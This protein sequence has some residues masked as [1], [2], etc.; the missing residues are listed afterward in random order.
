MA[1]YLVIQVSAF[2]SRYIPRPWRY[3]IGTAVGEAVYWA[4]TSK[5]Q[6]LLQNMAT[7]LGLDPSD[8]RVRPVARRSMRNYCKYLIEFLELP[9]LSAS[10]SVVASMRLEGEEHLTE[11]ISSGKGV[12]IVS[13][14]FGSMEPGGIRLAAMT[15]FHAVYDTFR[16]AY[17]DNLIRRKRLEKGMKLIPVNQIRQMLRV[18]HGGGTIITLLD[19]PMAPGKGIKVRFFG[20]NA[21]VPAGPAVLA[22]KTGATLLPIYLCRL[23]DLTFTAR[24][25]PAIGWTPSG[26]RDTDIQVITQKV[27]DTLQSVIR[28]HPDQWY[29]FRPMWPS[30]GSATPISAAARERATGEPGA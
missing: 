21:Y 7:V 27:M 9:N 19:R 29:M 16:P 1:L 24:I 3:A 5:R 14:H 12:I 17:L 18:L 13:G 6:T 23:P 4:W 11:A 30:D 25:L 22:M 8:P 2:L 20:R 28:E 10:H 26:D 15:D